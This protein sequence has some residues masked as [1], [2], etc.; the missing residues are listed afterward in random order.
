MDGYQERV[1]ESHRRVQGFFGANPEF[2]AA[3]SPVSTPAL[4]TQLDALN[5]VVDRVTDYATQQQ[6][7]YAQ[8]LLI[9]KDEREQRI[10]LR[11]EYMAPIAKMAHAL[12]GT[13]P[14]I[15]VLTMPK[16]N[17][18]GA[19]LI[20]AATVMAH[21]A[22]IYK[23]VLVENGLPEDFIQQLE[24]ATATLKQSLDAR[25]MARAARSAATRGLEADLALG[26]RIVQLM[27]VALQRILRGNPAKLAEWKH[28]KRVTV[29]GGSTRQVD[30]TVGSVPAASPKAA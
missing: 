26:R 29:K 13:V 1:T 18:Y 14:G 3:D 5:G 21:K 22:E 4:T 27:D 28:V 30:G 15:G 24:G 2:T 10:A 19:A 23:G 6:T 17:T 7:H 12:R 9:S 11:M 16:G 8:S 20:A 25:G